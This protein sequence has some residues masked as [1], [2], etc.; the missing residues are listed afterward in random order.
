MCWD[1]PDDLAR[2]PW[3]TFN[4]AMGYAG[5]AARK[6]RNPNSGADFVPVGCFTQQAGKRTLGHAWLV[7]LELMQSVLGN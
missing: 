7:L 4:A 5:K 2:R 6:K 1:K 3:R